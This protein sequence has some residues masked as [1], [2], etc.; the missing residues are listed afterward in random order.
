MRPFGARSAARRATTTP[1]VIKRAEPFEKRVPKPL[2]FNAA[3]A[4]AD[5]AQARR[6]R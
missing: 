6:A 4:Y 3:R 5:D 1:W 2:I